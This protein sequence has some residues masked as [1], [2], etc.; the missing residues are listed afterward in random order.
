MK[1]FF[2]YEWGMFDLNVEFIFF[3]DYYVSDLKKK[4]NLQFV[5]FKV[6][7]NNNFNLFVQLLDLI[8]NLYIYFIYIYVSLYLKKNRFNIF[9][10][11]IYQENKKRLN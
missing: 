1:V 10:F 5:V 4:Y 6:V 3:Y 7:N 9:K 8:F 2:S 11:Y